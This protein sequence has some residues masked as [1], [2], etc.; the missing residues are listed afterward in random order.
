MFAEW[1]ELRLVIDELTLCFHP[2]AQTL[3]GTERE[4]SLNHSKAQASARVMIL[5]MIS[6][7][8]IILRIP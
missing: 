5:G 7:L 3:L 6:I 8:C 2:I 1:K 4:S